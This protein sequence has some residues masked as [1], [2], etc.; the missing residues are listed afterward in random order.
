[1]REILTN[2]N[3]NI[4]PF[5]KRSCSQN[6]SVV[7]FLYFTYF[8]Y[9]YNYCRQFN[10]CFLI[11]LCRPWLLVWTQLQDKLALSHDKRCRRLSPSRK[12]KLYK[13]K[14]PTSKSYTSSEAGAL[15]HT[16]KYPLPPQCEKIEIKKKLLCVFDWSLNLENLRSDKFCHFWL[17]QMW[18]V[19]IW[20]TLFM[21]LW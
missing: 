19:S 5:L 14:Y 20:D 11:V 13:R 4:H 10:S 1:M 12:I 7:A 9:Y 15:L 17:D 18:S 2:I 8:S 3:S 21:Q 16:L 6:F